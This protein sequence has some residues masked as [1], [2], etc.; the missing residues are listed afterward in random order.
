MTQKKNA[1]QLIDEVLKG[2]FAYLNGCS[3]E[4]I[5]TAINEKLANDYMF[6]EDDFKQALLNKR[7]EIETF[8]GVPLN[9]EQLA[10]ITGGSKHLSSQ[11][12]WGIG[13]G[14]AFGGIVGGFFAVLVIGELIVM[15]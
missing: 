14:G 1:S 8:I 2:Q 6:T 4:D 12:K 10:A 15:K 7:N 5:A 13:I 9:E 11:A 3:Q